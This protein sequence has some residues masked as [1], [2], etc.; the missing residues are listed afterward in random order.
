[1]TTHHIVASLVSMAGVIVLSA[2]LGAA[3]FPVFVSTASITG[4]AAQSTATDDAT[5]PPSVIKKVLAVYPEEAK[6]K[7]VEGEVILS[8]R[9]GS[10]GTVTNAEVKKSVALLDDAAL[11]AIRQ[12]LF[13][14][15]RRGG[16]PVEV[17][18]EITFQFRLK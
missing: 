7:H 6:Q 11:T 17:L 3:A 1:M 9:I 2:R 14:P 4:A 15:A 10:D 5:D 13:R 12:W 16:K 18:T 8:V